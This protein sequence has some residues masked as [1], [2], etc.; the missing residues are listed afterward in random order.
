[1]ETNHRKFIVAGNHNEYIQ[2]LKENNIS[3]EDVHYVSSVKML[4]GCTNTQL[5]F[6]GTWYKRKDI[7]DIQTMAKIIS[8]AR[9]KVK[10]N[11]NS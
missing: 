3:S 10:E 8:V 5:V 2:Y 7:V 9:A 11:E 1:V 4:Y 6:T